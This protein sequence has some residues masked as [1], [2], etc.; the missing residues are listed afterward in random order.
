[1]IACGPKINNHAVRPHVAEVIA[2][3][4]IEKVYDKLEEGNVET[5][6]AD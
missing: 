4:R 1:M 3:Y 6:F 2:V 5:K